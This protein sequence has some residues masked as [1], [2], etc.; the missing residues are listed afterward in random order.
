MAS[1]H[2]EVERKYVVHDGPAIGERAVEAPVVDE[3]L[4]TRLGHTSG[5]RQIHHLDATYYDTAD[6]RLAAAKVTLRRRTGGGD[7]GWHLKLPQVGDERAELRRKLG[8]STNP[9]LTLTRLLRGVAGGRPLEP[10]AVIRTTRTESYLTNSDGTALAVVSQDNVTAHATDSSDDPM[11]WDE[12]EVELLDG[13]VSLLEQVDDILASAGVGRSPSPSKL[14]R[15]LARPPAARPDRNDKTASTVLS[16]YLAE[17]LVELVGA[18]LALRTVNAGV[19]DLR[20]E[21]RRLRTILAV[22]RKLFDET[23]AR[24]LKEELRWAGQ[25]FGRLRDIEVT[26]ERLDEAVENDPMTTPTKQLAVPIRRILRS[27]HRVAEDAVRQVLNSERYAALI[28]ELY[29]FVEGPPWSDRAENDAKKYLPKLSRKPRKRLRK[30]AK[31]LEQTGE[32]HA[33]RHEVRKAARRLRYALEVLQSIDKPADKVRSRAKSLQSALGDYLDDR[34]L[35]DVLGRLR[36]ESVQPNRMFTYGRLQAR[37][38]TATDAHL[39]SS[40]ADLKKTLKS[41]SKYP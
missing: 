2:R 34:D 6:L 39:E 9:P 23:S 19:H 41:A 25:I 12:I 18:D 26:F 5:P 24:H 35:A 4:A 32:G 20:V 7:A 36:H 8:R 17:H 30:A 37:V 33:E 29:E 13:D 15:V 40:R 1:Q 28:D 16:R 14:S 3:L 31:R 11:H 10:V 22:Y 27:D 21:S 38:E